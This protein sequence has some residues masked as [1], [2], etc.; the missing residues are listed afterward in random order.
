MRRGGR[1]HA[2]AWATAGAGRGRG[3]LATDWL[4]LAVASGAQFPRVLP[5]AKKERGPAIVSYA[6]W[7]GGP[8]QTIATNGKRHWRYTAGHC[9]AKADM[10]AH[11]RGLAFQVDSH[12]AVCMS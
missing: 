7:V 2:P 5:A 8:G 10:H 6:R 12:A 11:L 9:D 3:R 1:A 4:G